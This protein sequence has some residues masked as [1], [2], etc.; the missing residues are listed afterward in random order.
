MHP[1]SIAKLVASLGLLHGRRVYLNM[2][3]GGFKNDLTALG[4][5]TP[6]DER[7]ARLVEYTTLVTA[8][9]GAAGGP[10]SFAGRYYQV[11]NVKLAPCLPPELMPGVFVSGSSEA[12]LAAAQQ[13]GAL[14]VQYPK[15]VAEYE[16]AP[17][18]DA[19]SLGIRVGI[20]ARPDGHDAWAAARARFPEDRKGQVMHHLAM[21]VSDSEW[22]RQLSELGR[23]V[24]GRGDEEPYWMVPFENYKTFCPYLVG[25]YERVADEIARY[26]SVGYRTFILDVPASPDELLH[27]GVV[28]QRAAERVAS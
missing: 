10:V 2:V 3:A 4:D 17:P 26:V 15:P 9:L 6:H 25:S 27:A 21:T 16:A 19:R 28:F 12:G 5:P 7:Y 24:R 8:L 22:H 14:A 11:T 23:E 20:I 18:V 13:L 1:Y